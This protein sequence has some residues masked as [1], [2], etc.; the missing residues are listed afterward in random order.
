NSV[1]GDAGPLPYNQEINYF[2]PSAQLFV[3]P[4]QYS[5]DLFTKLLIMD[6]LN[7]TSCQMVSIILS[8]KTI[9][10]LCKITTSCQ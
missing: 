5:T 6:H 3:M 1:C 7:I 4:Y 9:A 2:D 8:R 10:V